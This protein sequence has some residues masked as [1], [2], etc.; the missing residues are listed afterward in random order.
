MIEIHNRFKK[1]KFRFCP[2][3]PFT[4]ESFTDHNRINYKYDDNILQSYLKQ[5]YNYGILVGYGFDLAIDIDNKEFYEKIKPLLPKTLE[6]IS[7]I[8]KLPH[9]F[10]KINF[11]YNGKREYRGLIDFFFKGKYIVGS[12]SKIKNDKDPKDTN[13][14]PYKLKYEDEIAELPEKTFK[15]IIRIVQLEHINTNDINTKKKVQKNP[16]IKFFDSKTDS[17]RYFNNPIEIKEIELCWK[18]KKGQYIIKAWFTDI[19][20]YLWFGLNNP[21]ETELIKNLG[22][23]NQKLFYTILNKNGN[24]MR[25]IKYV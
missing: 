7:G 18:N 12:N 5:N 11:E 17:K 4:K 8:K 25:Q 24:Y 15:E 6:Q 20:N 2:L 21:T 23:N 9:L 10:Y 1:D 16:N 13:I 3:K 22:K 14:Y 19:E